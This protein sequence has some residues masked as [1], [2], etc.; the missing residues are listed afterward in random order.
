MNTKTILL[1][2]CFVAAIAITG[3]LY[4]IFHNGVP[5]VISNAIAICMSCIGLG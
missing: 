1:L 4:G 5:A 3:I 2:R